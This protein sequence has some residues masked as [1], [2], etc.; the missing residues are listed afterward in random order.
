MTDIA[1]LTGVA[2]QSVR[3]M[4]LANED[5]PTPAHDGSML[6]WHLADVL[7]WLEGRSGY[8]VDPA[9]RETSEVVRMVNAAREARRYGTEELRSLLD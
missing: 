5:F 7:G 9:V 3:K 6:L 1:E 4:M 2:R 8:K